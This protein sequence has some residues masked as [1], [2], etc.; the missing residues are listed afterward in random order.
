MFREVRVVKYGFLRSYLDV[1]VS[2]CLR[3]KVFM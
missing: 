1:F 2:A 3:G